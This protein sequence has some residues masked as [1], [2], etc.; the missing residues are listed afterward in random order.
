VCV[1]VD[2]LLSFQDVDDVLGLLR[3]LG[4]V[5]EYSRDA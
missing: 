5:F 1:E 3:E 4:Q 2:L